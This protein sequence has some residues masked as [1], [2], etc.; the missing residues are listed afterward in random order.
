MIHNKTIIEFGGRIGV[1]IEI[2]DDIG[3]LAFT[4]LYE[5]LDIGLELEKNEELNESDVIFVFDN[6]KSIDAVISQLNKIKKE[7]LLYNNK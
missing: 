1:S 7:M 3:L 2:R 5:T 4:E 6:V